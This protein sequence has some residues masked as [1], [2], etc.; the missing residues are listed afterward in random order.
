[1][2]HAAI[3]NL[4]SKGVDMLR[5]PGMDQDDDGV[6]TPGGGDMIAWFHDPD[7]NVLSLTQV[8]AT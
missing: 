6:W 8:A 7:S 1:M 3:D 4:R 5:Y 2:S